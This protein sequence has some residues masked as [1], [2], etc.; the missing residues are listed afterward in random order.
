[1]QSY[2][3]KRVRHSRSV[4]HATARGRRCTVW[5]ERCVA[6]ASYDT[7]RTIST[8]RYSR[9]SSTGT[10]ISP[11]K[12]T[13]RGLE[14]MMFPRSSVSAT[15]MLPPLF[16]SAKET[17]HW[18]TSNPYQAHEAFSDV[19]IQRGLSPHPARHSSLVSSTCVEIIIFCSKNKQN[20]LHKTFHYI[21]RRSAIK[22]QLSTAKN[23]KPNEQ[24]TPILSDD[25]SSRRLVLQLAEGE[26]GLWTSIHT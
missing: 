13:F 17:L 7:Y 11:Q 18:D 5:S 20:Q 19:F 23:R 24:G 3:A 6:P 2:D 16:F 15:R 26:R 22:A 8:G 14:L 25:N 9:S 21:A 1:M 4:T 10:L 12:H